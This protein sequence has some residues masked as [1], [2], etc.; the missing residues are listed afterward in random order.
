MKS[1]FEQG[2]GDNRGAI[3]FKSRKVAREPTPEEKREIRESQRK[4]VVLWREDAVKWRSHEN[5]GRIR[6]TVEDIVKKD[7]K[8]EE[9]MRRP[10][11]EAV[12]EE[13]GRPLSS[14]AES[15]VLEFLA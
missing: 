3:E 1:P 11:S 12:D 8:L 7:K 14:I 4:L 9:I 13:F 15:M 10:P 6:P 5:E 2:G